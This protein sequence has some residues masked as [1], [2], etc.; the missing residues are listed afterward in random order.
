MI[1][2]ELQ[3]ELKGLFGCEIETLGDLKKAIEDYGH[4]CYMMGYNDR[5]EEVEK[6][7]RGFSY[8]KKS[9]MDGYE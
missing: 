2:R 9:D 8:A 1:T 4:E 7:F 5:C 6:Y 3:G